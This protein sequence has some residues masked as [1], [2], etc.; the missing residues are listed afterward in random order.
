MKKKY[1]YSMWAKML[2]NRCP[3][4]GWRLTAVWL[5]GPFLDYME[6]MNVAGN[7]ESGFLCGQ[8]AGPTLCA[9]GSIIVSWTNFASENKIL[10][11]IAYNG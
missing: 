3:A 4:G 6:G 1:F 7:Y 11:G 2:I 10:N 8:R 5:D 9:T